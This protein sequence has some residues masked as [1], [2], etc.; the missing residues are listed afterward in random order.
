MSLCD[1]GG[2]RTAPKR[3]TM[4]AHERMR[5]P[6]TKPEEMTMDARALLDQILQT[7]RQLAEQ[8]QTTAEKKLGIPEA[9]A[10]RE[11]ML[12]GMGKGAVAGGL[13]ALLLGTQG[14]RKVGGSALKLGSLAAIGGLAYKVFQEWQA[15]QSGATPAAGTPIGQLTGD[16][17]DDRSRAIL[18]AVIAAAKADGHID[19]EER[20]RI[21]EKI[22]ALNLDASAAQ[23]IQEE[24]VKPLDVQEVAAGA[25]SPEAAAEIYLASLMVI[26]VDSDQERTYLAELTKQLQLDAGLV[27]QL[28]QQ[29]SAA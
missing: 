7:G 11:A 27:A 20:E 28:E 5:N 16:R 25:D 10:E 18:R 29:A 8:G 4:S 3:F 2:W 19:D 22:R 13:L 26:N 21:G 23:F 9:G 12:S 15:K 14:G 17:A 6:M 1:P 24:I